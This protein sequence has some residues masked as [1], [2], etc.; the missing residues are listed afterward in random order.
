VTS[1]S[2]VGAGSAPGTALPS[3]A[4]ALEGDVAGALRLGDPPVIARV[5]DGRTLLD[6][7]SLPPDHDGALVDAVRALGR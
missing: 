4:V 1:S 3:V 5:E 2:L 7:R 6:L